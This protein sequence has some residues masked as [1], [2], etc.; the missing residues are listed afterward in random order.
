MMDQFFEIKEQN[1]GTILFFRMGDFYELFYEDAEVA[2][3]VLGLSLTARDK[4]AEKPIPMAGFPWHQLQDQLKNMLRAGFKVTVAEQEEELRD[5]A[6]LLERVVTRIYTPG[7]LYEENLIDENSTS[8]LCALKIDDDSV[9]FCYVDS[10]TGMLRS[11]S[12]SGI[13]RFDRCLDEILKWQ[14]TEIVLSPKDSESGEFCEML[15]SIDSMMISHHQTSS[16]Q[17]KEQLKK[18][19][20]LADLGSIDADS[21]PSALDASGLAADYLSKMQLTDFAM[22]RDVELIEDGTNL[23]LDQTTLRNLEIIQTL[24]GEYEGSLI[25]SMRA[26]KTAMGR[27]C[28]KRWLLNPLRDISSL[29]S[30]HD[31]VGKLMRSSRRLEMIREALTGIRDMERLAIRLSHGKADGRD[32]V[33]IADA[34]SRLPSLR[35][36]LK[37]C[38]DPLLDILIEDLDILNP[39]SEKIFATLVDNPPLTVKEGGLIRTGF[40]ENL[41]ELRNISDEGKSWF[42]ALERTLREDLGIPSLK[43]KHNRQIGWFIEVTKSN[44]SRVPDEWIRKQEM[45]N[46]SRYL[47][48]ELVER[49]RALVTSESKVKSIEY[50]HFLDLRKLV[51]ESSEV[52]SS[53][54]D[55]LS[56]IDVLQCFAKL[57][58]DRNWC[59]P[60]MVEDQN[61][62]L[63]EVRHPV[64]ELDGNFVPNDIL[65]DKNRSDYRT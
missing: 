65:F 26:C 15:K 31:S 60:E 11:A 25:G 29:K 43:V 14:P 45:T 54:A 44:L 22:I 49:D 21:S 4:K 2:S 55:R 16:E 38:E 18:M 42:S 64:I 63:K 52:I 27:R 48:Q 34:L 8:G 6:K 5:G 57:S 50:D 9:G 41:D 37:E 35:L 17:R 53:I 61:I 1:P 51:T 7:S 19:L 32:L 36:T 58:S 13:S 20:E 56:A 10:S 12:F 24:S 28:L 33:A 47:T 3:E 23:Q 46:G 30:R 39:L 40:D 59:R 62:N